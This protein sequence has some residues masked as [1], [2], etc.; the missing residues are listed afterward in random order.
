ML[1]DY[2]MAFYLTKTHILL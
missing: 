1:A 2:F